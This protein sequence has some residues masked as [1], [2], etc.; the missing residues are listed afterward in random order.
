LMKDYNLEVDNLDPTHSTLSTGAL[1]WCAPGGT[2]TLYPSGIPNFLNTTGFSDLNQLNLQYKCSGLDCCVN[3]LDNSMS[4]NNVIATSAA[5]SV[6]VNGQPTPSFPIS[7]GTITV[8]PNPVPIASSVSLTV[9]VQELS[10]GSIQSV[11]FQMQESVTINGVTSIKTDN[12]PATLS[13]PVNGVYTATA[14]FVIPSTV[15]PGT[16]SLVAVA[17]DGNGATGQSAPG[18][19]TVT[20]QVFGS[21]L[22]G[23]ACSSGANCASGICNSLG[24]CDSAPPK[25][26]GNFN[27]GHIL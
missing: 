14:A 20:P 9:A 21:G 13:T 6:F 12:L 2:T 22:P 18:S 24:V 25:T 4:G 26:F 19:I 3:Y 23:E 16:Y 10:P 15:S 11:V 8:S 7:G 27:N 1:H 5:M 17:T